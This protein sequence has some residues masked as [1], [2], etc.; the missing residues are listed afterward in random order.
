MKKIEISLS[1]DVAAVR[2][3][4]AVINEL[5][6]RLEDQIISESEQ[7][8]LLISKDMVAGPKPILRTLAGYLLDDYDHELGLDIKKSLKTQ[9]LKFAKDLK[10]AS[11]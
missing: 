3:T 8:S 10:E 2:A 9:M 7:D 11:K 4:P 1:N 6:M 5:R